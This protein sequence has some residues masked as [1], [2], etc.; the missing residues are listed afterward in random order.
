MSQNLCCQEVVVLDFETTGLSPDYAR[1]IEV[2]AAVFCNGEVRETFEELMDPGIFL[3]SCITELTGI[4]RAML[5]GKPRP[6][7]V[8]PRLRDFIGNRVVVAHNAS[9]DGKF[10]NA[11]MSRAGLSFA[12]PLLCTLLL[13]RRLL[14]G[15]PSYKLEILA[16]HLDIDSDCFHR[17]LDDVIVTGNL[18]HRLCQTVA[19]AT[20]LRRPDYEVMK[21]ICGKS[22]RAVPAYLQ[23]VNSQLASCP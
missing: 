3:P 7:A 8:M 16:R 19:N 15:L 21:T 1:I 23:A 20:G 2:G 4:S 17:A 13:A 14:P 9:F 11:E 10:L 6:E 18:W 5:R 12:S 22:K